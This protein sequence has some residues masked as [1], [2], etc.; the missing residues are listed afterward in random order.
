MTEVLLCDIT[1]TM[2]ITTVTTKGQATIP[3]EIRAKLA[4]VPGD[5]IMYRNADPVKRE[6]ILKVIPTGSVVDKLAGCLN[7]DG[8]VKYVPFEKARKISM[9]KYGEE[10]AKKWKTQS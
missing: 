3:V 6:V 5:R 8:K 4:V 2:N 10:W 7:L 9:K 1:I